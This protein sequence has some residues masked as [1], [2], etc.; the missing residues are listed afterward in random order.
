MLNVVQTGIGLIDSY[1]KSGMIAQYIACAQLLSLASL[2]FT[3]MKLISSHTP[4]YLPTHPPT[5]SDVFKFI[6]G[7]S[8]TSN[9]FKFI[10]GRK[11]Q[12]N[13]GRPRPALTQQH[14]WEK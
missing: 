13:G 9:V 7:R 5:T 12:F 8:C 14:R 3:F 10:D 11:R 6:G 4:T 2:Y 1:T